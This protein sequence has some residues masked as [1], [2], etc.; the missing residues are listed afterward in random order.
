MVVEKKGKGKKRVK[1]EN[2]EGGDF[3]DEEGGDFEEEEGGDF[4]ENGE[5]GGDFVNLSDLLDGGGDLSDA[6]SEED[7]EELDGATH[8]KFLSSLAPAKKRK[9]QEMSESRPESQWN[10]K[11]GA[12]LTVGDLLG[13]LNDSAK[14]GWVRSVG[15]AASEISSPWK[16]RRGPC[17]RLFPRSSP[18]GLQGRSPTRSPSRPRPSGCPLSPRCT[19]RTLC[20]SP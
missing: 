14:Y 18:T 10:I 12:K 6:E 9:A 3:E 16:A 17:R 13:T 5:E 11:S 15:S 20:P 7:E 2:E 19:A 1:F 8:A 4:E